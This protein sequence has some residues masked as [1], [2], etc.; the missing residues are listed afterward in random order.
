MYLQDPSAPYF[1]WQYLKAIHKLV[2]DRWWIL[3]G[4]TNLE[5][6]NEWLLVMQVLEL[7]LKARRDL[8]LLAQ[9]GMVGR[10]H[11][12][13]ILWHLLT[14]PAIDS[15][16]CDLSNLVTHEVYKARKNFDRPPRE[17]K[18]L[19]W[20]WW[21]CYEWAYARDRKWGPGEVP[22]RRWNLQRGPG[23]KPLE[24]PHCWG[25]EYPR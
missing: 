12:N 25:L 9:S 23:G 17:H 10:L 15:S 20:W 13:K 14:G 21:T 3:Q 22:K 4:G 1:E 7:D 16:Y 24:P 2:T 6:L 19:Q 11:A 8:F 18:D 5:A